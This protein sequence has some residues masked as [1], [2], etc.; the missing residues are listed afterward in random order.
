MDRT[1]RNVWWSSRLC[2]S[3]CDSRSF[4]PEFATLT[5]LAGFIVEGH[6]I[7]LLQG[8]KQPD[9]GCIGVQMTV[10]V[11]ENSFP[12]PILLAFVHDRQPLQNRS[13]FF[14]GVEAQAVDTVLQKVS[15]QRW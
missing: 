5:S 4:L 15:I 7:Y 1:Q 8:I 13:K 9:S 3:Y 6:D 12:E 2:A 14:Q 10:H 11:E